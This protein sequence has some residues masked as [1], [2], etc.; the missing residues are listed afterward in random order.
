MAGRVGGIP[1][2]HHEPHQV[3]FRKVFTA[4]SDEFADDVVGA[5]V[6]GL[7]DAAHPVGPAG[8]L[9]E[10]GLVQFQE[11]LQ[12]DQIGGFIRRKVK[13]SVLAV[14]KPVLLDDALGAAL[15][16]FGVRKSGWNHRWSLHIQTRAPCF[17]TVS[18]R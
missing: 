11:T 5:E 6:L 13:P 18:I 15:V 3:L 14:I 2:S 8:D 1:G 12:A 10:T 7:P 9:V 16:V 17:S 4:E